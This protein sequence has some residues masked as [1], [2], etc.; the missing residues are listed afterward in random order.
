MPNHILGVDYRKW[1]QQAQDGR[2]SI[3]IRDIHGRRDREQGG[4]GGFNVSLLTSGELRCVLAAYMYGSPGKE[5]KTSQVEIF[6]QDGQREGKKNLVGHS[7]ASMDLDGRIW[8]QNL[9][10]LQGLVRGET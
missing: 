8:R 2:L 3:A 6:N 4:I 9:G 7:R 10:C 5:E 1:L